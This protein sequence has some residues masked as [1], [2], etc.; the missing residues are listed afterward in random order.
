MS[1]ELL[2]QLEEQ[3]TTI[4]NNILL[5]KMQLTSI[6]QLVKTLEKDVK[7]AVKKS[8]KQEQPKQKRV[9]SGFAK[10]T[11]VSKELCEFMNVPEG[12][13]LARTEVTKALVSYIKTNKL[14][15]DN[16]TIINPDNTLKQLLGI[17]QNP[18]DDLNYFNIQKYMNRHFITKNNKSKLT[19]ENI[20]DKTELSMEL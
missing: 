13:E 3:F 7:K 2:S 12:S 4:N 18:I 20:N 15:E 14:I 16:K 1:E 10:P 8:V 6:Q 9:P 11:K 19:K 17:G 5:F